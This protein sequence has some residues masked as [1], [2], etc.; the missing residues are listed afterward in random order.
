M[1]SIPFL[2]VA[3]LSLIPDFCEISVDLPID[4]SIN[5]TVG[6][7]QQTASGVQLIKAKRTKMSFLTN[8]DGVTAE[9]YGQAI[10]HKIDDQNWLVAPMKAAD[11][12]KG[13]V[14]ALLSNCLIDPFKS[15]SDNLIREID[16]FVGPCVV[17]P[18]GYP[19]IVVIADPSLPES[20]QTID[21]FNNSTRAKVRISSVV[22]GRS[23][24]AI[25]SG[26]EQILT[27]LPEFRGKLRNIYGRL[28][29]GDTPNGIPF[30]AQDF[31][32]E[33]VE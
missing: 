17:S 26:I 1:L 7:E 27:W 20:I 33:I 2:C 4:V 30:T 11:R 25:S 14:A 12:N 22:V 3:T 28:P 23:E 21:S 19:L 6:D 29:L 16:A 10:L 18:E 32:K 31:S 15:N 5:Y 8:V 24:D 9:A 13:Y